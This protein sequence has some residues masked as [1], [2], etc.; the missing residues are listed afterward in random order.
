[1]AMVTC[2]NASGSGPGGAPTRRAQERFRIR[3]L[4]MALSCVGSLAFAPLHAVAEDG[5]APAQS[6]TQPLSIAPSAPGKA[7]QPSSK[8]RKPVV[9]RRPARPRAASIPAKAARPLA[10]K[11]VA[12][13]AAST[14]PAAD[15]ASP[16][17]PVGSV[18]A[19]RQ[20]EAEAQPLAPPAAPVS[21]PNLPVAAAKPGTEVSGEAEAPPIAP[22]AELPSPGMPGP[23]QFAWKVLGGPAQSSRFNWFTDPSMD[24]YPLSRLFPSIRSYL[25]DSSVAAFASWPAIFSGDNEPTVTRVE[26]QASLPPSGSAEY[27]AGLLEDRPDTPAFPKVQLGNVVWLKPTHQGASQADG[28]V[29]VARITISPVGLVAEI[30]VCCRASEGAQPSEVKIG[31]RVVTQPVQDQVRSVGGVSMRQTGN[32]EGDRLAGAVERIGPSDYRVNL[33]QTPADLERNVRLLLGR[34]WI[35]I[36]VA[37]ASGRRAILTFTTGKVGADIIDQALHSWH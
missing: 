8:G 14:P 26:E 25:V 10:P 6:D 34:P 36:P 29:P 21:E 37:F 18:Q 19:G 12:S 7:V 1:M 24:Q 20:P 31:V 22:V 32:V 23:P 5:E 4:L 35:D 11:P 9:S 28:G 2:A 33:S 16:P 13:S 17:A 30:T 27:F 15:P 3:Y